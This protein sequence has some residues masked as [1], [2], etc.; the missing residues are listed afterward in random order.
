[1]AVVQIM[2]NFHF[3]KIKHGTPSIRSSGVPSSSLGPVS[4]S[5]PEQEFIKINCDA[6]VGSRFSSIAV[7]AR[8]WQGNLVFAFSKK[9]NTIIPLQVEAKALFWAGQLASS[10][11]LGKVILKSDCKL[12]VDTSVVDACIP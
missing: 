1:V 3:L 8:D 9:V 5:L 4:W 6:A 12:V 2:K 7:V 10:H 11:E